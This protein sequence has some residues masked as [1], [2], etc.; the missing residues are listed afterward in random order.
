MKKLPILYKKTETG[1]IQQWQIVADNDGFYTIE[2]QVGGKFTTSMPTKCEGKNA[3]KA[4]ETTPQT[5]AEFEAER[6]WKKQ[7]D[8]GY[9]PDI[10]KVDS[11]V[12]YIKP[13]LAHK[14]KDYKDEVSYPIYVQRKSDGARCVMTRLGAWTRN[15]N[16]WVTIPHIREALKPFFQ[17]YP[18]AILDGELYNHELHDNFDKIM[19]LVKKTKPSIEDL[20]EAEEM[21]QYHVYDSPKIRTLNE[22]DPF[23]NR[24]MALAEELKGVKHVRIVE[25]YEAKNEKD[26]YEYYE[27]FLDEG[28]E[29]LMIRM[30]KP[31][32]NKRTKY[33][34]KVKPV[35]TE[36]FRIL[37]IRAGKGN[38]ANM[39][40]HAD[41]I[42]KQGKRFTANI[43]GT[44]VYL[45][46]LLEERD[47]VVGK[48][49]T[50]QYQNITPDGVPRF[51]YM[52]AVRDYE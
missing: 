17:K 41:F 21:V 39:A 52:I 32:Q 25:T 2:G 36:E 26:M 11:A 44:H 50:V 14:F 5:Q 29:G 16:E 9:T 18:N 31:Y 35:E 4:N 37:N 15:G 46:K 43:K 34:L 1:A 24:Y 10:D 42:T 47:E 8:K 7:T 13:M 49:A 38:K 33:L 6:K 51:P 20:F 19:S 40:A 30:N 12:T 22:K 28:Y 48:Q 45:K 27:K 23:I 3:G